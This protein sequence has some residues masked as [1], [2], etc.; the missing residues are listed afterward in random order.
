MNAPLQSR[1]QRKHCA[2]KS[3]AATV[4]AL[5]VVVTLAVTASPARAAANDARAAEALHHDLRKLVAAQEDTGWTIDAYE[6]EDLA[7]D[8]LMSVC[9]TTPAVRQAALDRAEREVARHGGPLQA[10]FEAEGDLDELGELVSATRVR[11]LL[12]LTLKR[13]PDDCMPWIEVDEA[14]RGRQ[15]DAYRIT[16]NVEAGGLFI[17]QTSGGEE[18]IGAGG[19]GRLL[20]L[21]G[22]DH[23]YSLLVGAELGGSTLFQ[24]TEET[25]QFPLRFQWAFPL[26]LRHHWL[27]FHNDLE[28]APLIFFTEED[29]PASYGMRVGGLVGVST[30]RILNIMPWAGVGL[31][32]EH[33]FASADRPAIG[34]LK[35]GARVG[36]D[37]D[38]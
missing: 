34:T 23:D 21:Y 8:A 25:T 12:A 38:F 22:F 36:F 7:P 11:D 9:R 32:F 18:E 35:G 15:T 17:A 27:T 6:L 19:S 14:F 31:A 26:V 3:P 4:A 30:F 2:G 1:Q 20:L 29:E 5:S 24:R 16:L 33:L 10:A 37:W 28:V 13:A